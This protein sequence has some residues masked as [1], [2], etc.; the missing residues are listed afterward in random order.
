LYQHK[1][2]QHSFLTPTTALH[3]A[4]L[5]Q[6]LLLAALAALAALVFSAMP[7]AVVAET[8]VLTKAFV[9]K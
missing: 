7:M 9:N 3:K 5:R 8:Q 6:A 4:L 2:Q 1:A